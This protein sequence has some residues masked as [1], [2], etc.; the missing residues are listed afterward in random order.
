[1]RMRRTLA[2]IVFASCVVLVV[3]KNRAADLGDDVRKGD[4]TIIAGPE[5]FRMLLQTD[6]RLPARL[7]IYADPMQEKRQQGQQRQ[8]HLPGPVPPQQRDRLQ[9]IQT[10]KGTISANRREPQ[11]WPPH[12]Q[13]QLAT[14]NNCNPA[15]V[16]T[17]HRQPTGSDPVFGFAVLPGTSSKPPSSNHG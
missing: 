8:R 9:A 6:A 17:N 7:K 15:T 10:H 1:M 12:Q 11:Q 2:Y 16:S 4:W 3:T 13:P 14:S 5:H